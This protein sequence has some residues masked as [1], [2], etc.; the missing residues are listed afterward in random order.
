M[1]VQCTITF[2]KGATKRVIFLLPCCAV[3]MLILLVVGLI[4]CLDAL[5]VVQHTNPL[6]PHQGSQ[7][8][9]PTSTS[10][11]PEQDIAMAL[12]NICEM[13]TLIMCMESNFICMYTMNFP[14]HFPCKFDVMHYL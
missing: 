11:W 3:R 5:S 2:C 9:Q 1:C 7:F 13:G 14:Q 10:L 12:S 4:Y 6:R 8:S